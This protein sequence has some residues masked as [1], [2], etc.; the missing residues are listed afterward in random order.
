MKIQKDYKNLIEAWKLCSNALDVI[1]ET[2][3]DNATDVR[4]AEDALYTIMKRNNEWYDEI[5][6][7]SF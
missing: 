4:E 3:L 5:K 7:E 2:L 6:R 1:K